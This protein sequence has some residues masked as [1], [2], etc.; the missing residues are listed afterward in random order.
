[1]IQ[2]DGGGGG[3]HSHQARGVAAEEGDTEEELLSWGG[4]LRRFA[5]YKG[6][7]RAASEETDHTDRSSC[8][9][10]LN[11][12]A[13]QALNNLAVKWK[14]VHVRGSEKS[15]HPQAMLKALTDGS[16]LE[17]IGADSMEEHLQ[18]ALE[19]GESPVFV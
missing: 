4:A 18:Q 9:L 8:T 6:G 2:V 7:M 17:R 16:L 11:K 14:Y 3:H 10:R 12:A 5:R 1:M 13:H 15:P 19:E